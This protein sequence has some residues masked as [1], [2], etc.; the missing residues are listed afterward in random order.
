M[1]LFN[2]QEL[3]EKFEKSASSISESV[4][5]SF[6]EKILKLS[7][8]KFDHSKTY[9]IF[10]SHSFD[11]ARI[12]KALRDE[13]VTL[14][15]SVYVDW[16]EDTKLNR[17]KVTTYNALVL[18]NRMKNCRCLF[19]AISEAATTSVWMPWE[20]GFMDSHTEKVAILPILAKPSRSKQF[21][22]IEYLGIYPYV[23]KTGNSLF[24]HESEKKWIGFYSWMRGEKSVEH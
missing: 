7:A 24:I 15:Y 19:Y 9:D 21:S 18:R 23:E 13:L 10:L 2:E 20:L 1:P 16:I 12:I 17:E 14:N 3:L 5:Y 6:A 11:D 22:G 8:D 4:R